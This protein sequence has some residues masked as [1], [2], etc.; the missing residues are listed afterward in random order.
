MTRVSTTPRPATRARP[1]QR[2]AVATWGPATAL[3][4][5]LIGLWE[6]VTALADVPAYLFPAPSAI[7][8]AAVE[9]RELLVAAT[10]VTTTEVVLGL[11]VAVVVALLIAV[12][13]HFSAILRTTVFPLL[14]ASQTVPIVVLAPILAIVFGYG[15]EPKLVI[16]ALICF[17]PIV[18]NTLDGLRSVDPDLPRLM[19]TLSATRWAIFS[20]V[21]F[22]SALPRLFSGLRVAVTYAPIGAVFGEWSGS[23]DGLGF[24]ML[25]ATPQLRTALVFAA[26]AVLT[27]E[28]VALFLL[29]RLVENVTLRWNRR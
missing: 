15:V 13:L 19:R 11:L 27:V 25:Q 24:V 18:V 23:T 21:E 9:D 14:I 26:I 8:R 12:A 20:K 10:L 2:G 5:A 7:V 22:P 28:S 4:V 3:V 17:F 29:V 6:L 16:V 1:E